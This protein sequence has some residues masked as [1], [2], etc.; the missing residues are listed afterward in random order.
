MNDEQCVCGHGEL[1]HE[2]GRYKCRA[3]PDDTV[4]CPMFVLDR[5]PAGRRSSPRN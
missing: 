3:C 1:D 5:G 2:G 4:P